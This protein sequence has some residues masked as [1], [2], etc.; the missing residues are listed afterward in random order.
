L[1]HPFAFFAKES[2]R[3]GLF[4]DSIEQSLPRSHRGP[5]TRGRKSEQRAVSAQLLQ[6]EHAAAAP[7]SPSTRDATAHTTDE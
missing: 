6:F 2:E 7:V 4:R 3:I 5:R 1:P